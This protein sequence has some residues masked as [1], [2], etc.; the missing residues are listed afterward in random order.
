[1]NVGI[2]VD[3]RP[4]PLAEHTGDDL[5]LGS[6]PAVIP[7]S[8]SINL[9]TA[10]SKSKEIIRAFEER[11]FV[12]I[13]RDLSKLP[14]SSHI[15]SSA[16]FIIAP[17]PISQSMSLPVDHNLQSKSMK[18]LEQLVHVSKAKESE[19]VLIC[20]ILDFIHSNSPNDL[21]T[22]S[23]YSN[24][25]AASKTLPHRALNDLSGWLEEKV[26]RNPDV[27]LQIKN[28]VAL[29]A[30]RLILDSTL[31]DRLFQIEDFNSP[32]TEGMYS[33]DFKMTRRIREKVQEAVG[34]VPG[35]V[36]LLLVLGIDEARAGNL[37]TSPSF[38][39]IY[40][41]LLVRNTNSD[42]D[43]KFEF[44]KLALMEAVSKNV[45]VG[46]S[47]AQQRLLALFVLHLAIGKV[48]HPI[49]EAQ[50]TGFKVKLTP[51]SDSVLFVPI[52][53][54]MVADTPEA[55]KLARVHYNLCRFCDS[56]P[57]DFS[58]KKGPRIPYFLFVYYV[59]HIKYFIFITSS[60]QELSE[61]LLIRTWGTRTT[62]MFQMDFV[63]SF[64]STLALILSSIHYMVW[65]LEWEI[66]FSKRRFQI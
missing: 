40:M 30:E 51:N 1:V 10:S 27:I 56:D 15:Y 3:D 65:I 64:F 31:F 46:A 7:L 20:D 39:G 5:A 34:L 52:V 61:N 44:F 2:A 21:P 6:F 59:S 58:H 4:L 50:R 57:S 18:C 14:T 49:R 63:A 35:A 42:S 32:L 11:H 22:S 33:P 23:S 55:A 24:F 38:R 60:P 28:S 13:S 8:D 12:G 36:P 17:L 54:C 48:L 37:G 47:E 43:S 26:M 19:G 29:L 25:I 9:D 16:D 53:V 66:K 62:I 45:F 41:Q